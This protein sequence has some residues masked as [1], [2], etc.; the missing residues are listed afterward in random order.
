MTKEEKLVAMRAKDL[1]QY[2]IDHGIK[3][4]QS[5]GNLKEARGAV[6]K[7]ILD[8]EGEND[9]VTTTGQLEEPTEG[10]TAPVEENTESGADKPTEVD[11]R[12]VPETLIR[13]AA[14]RKDIKVETTRTKNNNVIHDVM[15]NGEYKFS[16]MIPNEDCGPIVGIAS[17]TEPIRWVE[18]TAAC[19]WI[20]EQLV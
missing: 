12:T 5:H 4:S 20:E 10:C 19:E 1:V 18:Y 13:A 2:C 6:I 9:E 14:E 8:A 15:V 11:R 16:I 17:I 3:V 7:R